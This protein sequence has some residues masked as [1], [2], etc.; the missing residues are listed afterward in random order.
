MGVAQFLKGYGGYVSTTFLKLGFK[1]TSNS[2]I[3]CILFCSNKCDFIIIV[4]L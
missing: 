2:S 4:T 3:Y 1:L